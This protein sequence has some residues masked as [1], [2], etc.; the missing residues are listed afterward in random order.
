MITMLK[1]ALRDWDQSDNEISNIR[2]VQPL[3]G[4]SVFFYDASNCKTKNSVVPEK[5][6]TGHYEKVHKKSTEYFF[7]NSKDPSWLPDSYVVS[8]SEAKGT[9][10]GLGAK[11][12]SE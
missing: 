10:E 11:I 9:P 4:R 3:N 12:K 7:V 1:E 6:P 5:K 2:D 8:E